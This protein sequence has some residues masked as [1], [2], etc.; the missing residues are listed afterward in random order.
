MFA[1]GIGWTW[2]ATPER[3]ARN[4]VDLARF[5]SRWL[6]HDIRCP[7]RS[8]ARFRTTRHERPRSP[9]LTPRT[10]R[11][12]CDLAISANDDRASGLA[13]P[14]GS[15]DDPVVGRF[16]IDAVD[17]RTR[18]R[19]RRSS[20]QRRPRRR[21]ARRR[22]RDRLRPDRPGRRVPVKRDPEIGGCGLEV[23]HAV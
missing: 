10:L 7:C 21:S 9:H 14:P 22:P 3:V 5:R 13:R 16:N 1:N 11:A 17:G 12:S 18:R 4:I 19:Q 2:S 8:N 20:R 6:C 15:T 23:S